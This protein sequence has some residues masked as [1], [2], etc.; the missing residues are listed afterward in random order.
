M[1]L[2]TNRMFSVRSR[3]FYI[4]TMNIIQSEFGGGSTA[5]FILIQAG[6]YQ[7]ISNMTAAQYYYQKSKE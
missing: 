7:S 3:L 4:K 5:V 1:V 2:I 6:A